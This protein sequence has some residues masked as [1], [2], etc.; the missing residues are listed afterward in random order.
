MGQSV[1]R[2]A[3]DADRIGTTTVIAMANNATSPNRFTNPPSDNLPA[4]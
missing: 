2:D 4:M 1:Q 3:L